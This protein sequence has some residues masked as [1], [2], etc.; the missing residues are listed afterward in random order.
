MIK[1]YRKDSDISYSLGIS[2]TIE[3]LR[4]RSMETIK[5]YLS[6]DVSED[7]KGVS[8]IKNI[9]REKGISW[10]INKSVMDRISVTGNTYTA[11]VYKKY[12]SDLDPM[13]NHIV[14]FEPADMGNLGTICRTMC[15]Y[16]FKDLAIVKPAVDIFD[17]KVGRSSMGAVYT[18]NYNYFNSID[19]YISLYKHTN[20]FFVT[21]GD[22][23]LSKTIFNSPYSI[24]FGNE[25]KGL[26]ADVTDKGK[27]VRIPQ[28]SY[29]DSL[30]L[31]VAVGIALYQ[32][33]Q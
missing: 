6:P 2:P 22:S 4:N 11:G 15:A 20:Y 12:T 10:E 7:S 31:S 13:G 32:I 30:N 27:R 23:I 33:N 21:G 24:F 9:C 5:V 3:L 26:P 17:P 29:V 16:G 14:L 8:E 18:V 28:S 19:E 25:G 1:R